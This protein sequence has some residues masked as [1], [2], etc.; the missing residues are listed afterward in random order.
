[1]KKSL[2][3]SFLTVATITVYSLMTQEFIKPK[4]KKIYVSEQ[5]DIELDGDIVMCGTELSGL[6]IELSKAVFLVTKAAVGR[7]N[8]YA[9][10]EKNCLTKMERTEQY[11]KKIKIKEKIE[12]CMRQI[13]NMVKTFNAL[14]VS[15]D[16]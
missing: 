10:G 4:T 6:L 12:E 9:C 1:M 11:A 15:L 5:Q 2:I 16:E 14:I 3:L 7:V 8:N 13:E